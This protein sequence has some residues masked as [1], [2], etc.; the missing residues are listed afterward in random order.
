MRKV[1]FKRKK[2]STGIYLPA[3]GPYAG[4]TPVLAS[5]LSNFT[6]SSGSTSMG[7]QNRAAPFKRNLYTIS[8]TKIIVPNQG[9]CFGWFNIC[10]IGAGTYIHANGVDGGYQGGGPD[11]ANG[12]SGGSGGGGGASADSTLIIPGG[13]S[14]SG[15]D[16][17]AGGDGDLGGIGGAGG[18]G[19]ANSRWALDGY[20]YPTGGNASVVGGN[21]FGGGGDGLHADPAITG[22]DG[23]AG[24]PGGGGIVVIVCNSLLGSGMIKARGGAPGSDVYTNFTFEGGGGAILVCAVHYTGLITVDVSPG[25]DGG[26][27]GTSGTAEIYKINPD[28]SLTAKLWTD[29]W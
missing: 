13:S 11:G 12:G 6:S 27:G 3:A 4:L 28:M 14:V 23:A 16:G 9:S 8:G 20:T 7:T 18:S 24:G 5:S 1:L 29:V 21:G 22:P 17:T 26:F 2:K 10:T 25:G 15:T 19:Y